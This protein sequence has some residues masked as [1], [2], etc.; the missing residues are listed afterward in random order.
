MGLFDGTTNMFGP[1]DQE[2]RQRIL[3]FL[4]NPSE[5]NWDDIFS[6]I[7]NDRAKLSGTRTI[8]QAVLAIDPTFPRT[9]SGKHWERVPDAM[10]VARA[11]RAAVR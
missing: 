10:T 4:N 11:I 1:L 5:K 9:K 3:R 7:I 8:W 2:I 6:I